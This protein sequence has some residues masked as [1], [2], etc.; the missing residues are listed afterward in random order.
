M[1][2]GK[3]SSDALMTARSFVQLASIH[4]RNMKKPVSPYRLNNET[5]MQ[6]VK[7]SHGNTDLPLMAAVS[8]GSYSLFSVGIIYASTILTERRKRERNVI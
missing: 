4:P 1:P 5:L 3:P 2:S 8:W 6:V 7:G